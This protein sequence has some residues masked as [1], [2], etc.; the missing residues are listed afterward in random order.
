MFLPAQFI[1]TP[2]I[3]RFRAQGKNCRDVQESNSGVKTE[4]QQ[5]EHALTVLCAYVQK[6]GLKVYMR[7]PHA[8]TPMLEEGVGGALPR[9]LTLG[10]DLV[11]TQR[12]IGKFSQRDAKVR[13]SLRLCSDLSLMLL[14]DSTIPHA[15]LAFCPVAIPGLPRVCSAP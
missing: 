7:D 12:E 2:H 13:K 8:F 3:Q 4:R 6:H 15:S 11:M 5:K 10:A 9:S 1:K 14:S